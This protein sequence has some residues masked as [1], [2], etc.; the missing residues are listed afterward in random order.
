MDANAR[1]S[2]ATGSRPSEVTLCW[3]SLANGGLWEEDEVFPGQEGGELE[4]GPVPGSY[5]RS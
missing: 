3:L 4:A 1:S 2:A 5:V